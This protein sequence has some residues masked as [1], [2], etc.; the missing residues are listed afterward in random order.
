MDLVCWGQLALLILVPTTVIWLLSRRSGSSLMNIVPMKVN[1]FKQDNPDLQIIVAG[2]TKARK[3]KSDQKPRP[4]GLGWVMAGRSVLILSEDGL[5][6]GNRFLPLSTIS[7]AT[8]LKAPT[9]DILKVSTTDDEYYQFGLKNDPA[10]EEQ[11]VLPIKIERAELIFSVTGIAI[12]L[13]IAGY[14]FWGVIR[15]FVQ[16]SFDYYSVFYIAFAIYFLMPIIRIIKVKMEQRE[17]ND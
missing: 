8:L 6:F 16:Q 10:W 2:S 1:R 4:I 3:L 9:V 11:L 7:D 17:T 5:H 13:A 15:D 14:V 12:R